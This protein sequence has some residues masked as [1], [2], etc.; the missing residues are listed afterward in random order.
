ME[1]PY[2]GVKE[3]KGRL[4]AARETL[5][6]SGRRRD[7]GSSPEPGLLLASGKTESVLLC[8]AS[9]R[10]PQSTRGLVAFLGLDFHLRR[11]RLGDMVAVES[12]QD[13]HLQPF[14]NGGGLATVSENTPDSRGLY[15]SEGKRTC[16]N[17]I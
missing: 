10:L 14:L 5:L 6:N 15:G 7:L 17:L 11:A 9:A 2:R 16:L 12:G 1:K 13:N 8:L 3:G 4:R